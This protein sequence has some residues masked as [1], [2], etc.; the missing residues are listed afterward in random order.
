MKNLRFTKGA[1]DIIF[2]VIIAVTL[3][4]FGV[5]EF[6][7][8]E[9]SVAVPHDGCVW[10]ICS[11]DTMKTSRDRAREELYDPGFDKEIEREVKAIK[12]VGA[13]YIAIDTPYDEEFRPYLRR[14]VDIARE[15]DLKIWFRGNWSSWEGWFDYPKNMTPSEHIA[16]T[17]EFI[18]SNPELFE[19]GDIFDA[20]PECENSGHWPQP[21]KNSEYLSFL[22]DQS[23]SLDS[24]F[25]EI[26]RDVESDIA[27]VIG[28]RAKEVIDQKTVDVLDGTVSIDHYFRYPEN[29]SDYISFFN[30]TYGAQTV[31]SEF[32]AP[33]PDINGAMSESD[34]ARYIDEV[35]NNIYKSGDMVRGVNYWAFSDGTTAIVNDDGGTRDAY[36][37]IQKYFKPG[38]VRGHVGDPTGDDVVGAKVVTSDGLV[39]VTESDGEYFL[40]VPRRKTTVTVGGDKYTQKEIMVDIKENGQ[41]V[42][43]DIVIEPLEKSTW[44][45]IKDFLF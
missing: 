42:T 24:A 13:N 28:G 5:R 30:N 15:N 7:L 26:D 14:W 39:T 38:V 25:D 10:E 44:Y 2:F 4:I 11:I 6:A 9:E 31:V 34:Q 40:L 20:C 32:G 1:T 36:D 29:I 17:R 21:A 45:K 3:L 12:E 33:I 19:N 43:Q 37:V 41:E 8:S 18:L 27:S 22:R 35:L 16:K 23:E